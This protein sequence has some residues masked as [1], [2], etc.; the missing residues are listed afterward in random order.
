[1][2]LKDD[3]RRLDAARY[4]YA[5][6]TQTRFGDMDPNRH[7]N[8]VAIARL[9]EE[10]RVRFHDHLRAQHPGIGRP[11]FLVAHVA[12]DFL[13]EGRYPDDVTLRLAILSIGTS[14]YRIGQALFQ[15]DQAIALADSVIVYRAADRPGS[16]PLPPALRQALEG[17]ALV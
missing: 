9:L 8:N 4:R 17:Y 13:A 14:S 15:S 16:A 5:F 1:M 12:I 10:G 7:L 2:A 6:A 11:H 3:P